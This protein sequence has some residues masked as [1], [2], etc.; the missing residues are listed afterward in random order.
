M[1]AGAPLSILRFSLTPADALAYER[2]PG[3]L[4]GWAKACLVISLAAVGGFY[5]FVE[6]WP[7][8][9]RYGVTALLVLAWLVA[10][11]TIRTVLMHRRAKA[12]AARDGNVEIEEWYDHLAIRTAS[13]TRVLAVETIGKVLGGEGHVF[14]LHHGGPTIVPL[15]AFEDAEAMRAFGEALERR[16][17]DAVA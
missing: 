8:A 6:D 12:L 15:R 3:E 17:A 2:L 16:S 9:W 13:G 14:I 1:S 4:S 7:A 5:G 11:M 10:V